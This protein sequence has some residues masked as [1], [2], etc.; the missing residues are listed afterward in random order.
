MKTT[1][2]TL[3]SNKMMG[4]YLLIFLVLSFPSTLAQTPPNDECE[5]SL[6]LNTAPSSYL[7]GTT[8]E[9]TPEELNLCGATS[10]SKRGIWYLY[11]NSSIPEGS[12]Q[13]VTV[14]TC[15]ESTDFDT[16]LTLYEGFCEGL[17]CVSG[18]DNDSE[19]GT[20]EGL[21]TTL[22]WHAQSGTRYYLLVHGSQVNHTGNF[23]LQVT[24]E[25]PLDTPVAANPGES[26]SGTR[27]SNGFKIWM[28]AAWLV[29]V[30]VVAVL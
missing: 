12:T 2:Y 25:E 30:V 11:Q 7:E 3:F 19:C 9:A 20:G 10:A 8:V 17:Q 1:S 23:G 6:D 26:P 14:S 22:S 29:V 5:G 15:T 24:T 16:A 21:H 28:V 18:I 4:R 13:I 27:R